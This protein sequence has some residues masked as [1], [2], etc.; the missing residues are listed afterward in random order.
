MLLYLVAIE[1]TQSDDLILT[2]ERKKYYLFGEKIQFKF[3]GNNK[4]W[5]NQKTGNKCGTA[6]ATRLCEIYKSH[7]RVWGKK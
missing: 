5:Y 6:L 3:V 1:E 4:V 2:L 7:R